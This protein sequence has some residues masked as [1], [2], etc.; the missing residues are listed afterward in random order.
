M[1]AWWP[2]VDVPDGVNS[3]VAVLVGLVT[4]MSLIFGGVALIRASLRSGDVKA[5]RESNDDLRERIADLK[6]EA[7]ERDR[8]VAAL[9]LALTNE[10][11][12]RK[13]L[14]KVVTG[15]ELL[16]AIQKELLT[17]DAAVVLH[18]RN[19]EERASE[20]QELVLQKL[21]LIRRDII[22]AV[23]SSRPLEPRGET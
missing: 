16:E 20:R 5:L 21:D 23:R 9:A 22:S 8:K 4:L 14:E 11:E 17:H 12:A 3:W 15:R 19:H 7:E 1:S 18:H 10:A 13:V 6:A 2:L